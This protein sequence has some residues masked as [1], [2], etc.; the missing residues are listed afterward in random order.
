MEPDKYDRQVAL[1]CPI[2]GSSQFETGDDI[3]ESMAIVKCIS[4]GRE[5]TKD[6]LIRENGENIDEHIS[7]I[8]KESV[9]DAAMELKKTIKKA[10]QANKNIRFK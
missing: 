3:E 5:F 7:E 8:R 10:F 4:C 6:V 2:C 1:V 9:E